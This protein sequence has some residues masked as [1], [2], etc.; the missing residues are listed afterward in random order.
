MSK[1]K[2]LPGSYEREDGY[3]VDFEQKQINKEERLLETRMSADEADSEP[4]PEAV[5][6]D[7][8]W[9]EYTDSLGRSR[10]CLRK[11]LPHMQEIDKSIQP[12][13]KSLPPLTERT[14]LSD[15]MKREMLRQKWEK[16]EEEMMQRQG[17][18]HYENVRFDGQWQVLLL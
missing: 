4:I 10:L 15:D 5:T 11:D 6:Q 17:P 14:L 16:E 9:V 12:D 8:E 1:G 2:Q 13:K 18:T 7:E 3:L